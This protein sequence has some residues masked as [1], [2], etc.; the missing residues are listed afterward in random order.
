MAKQKRRSEHNRQKAERKRQKRLKA[1]EL[2]SPTHTP[3]TRGRKQIPMEERRTQRWFLVHA[4]SFLIWVGV[5]A[6]I[7][8]GYTLIRPNLTIEPDFLEN[9]REPFSAYFR[10]KNDGYFSIYDVHFS[11][12]FTGGPFHSVRTGDNANN[13]LPERVIA[14]GDSATKNCS[15]K[16]LSFDGPAEILFRAAFRPTLWPSTV[17]RTERFGA[18][19]DARRIY[20]WVHQPRMR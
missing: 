17:T 3:N 18:V 13:Q 5:V 7:G 1:V 16:G 20:H 4:K 14:P 10:V 19:Q 12:D 8:G 11:C 2:E 15:V 6:S 9:E